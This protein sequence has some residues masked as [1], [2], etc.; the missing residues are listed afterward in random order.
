M[1]TSTETGKP[2][3]TFGFSG[4][5]SSN[6]TN[7]G[8]SLLSKFGKSNNDDFD[9]SKRS[10]STKHLSFLENNPFKYESSDTEEDEGKDKS[11]N[12]CLMVLDPME[13]FAQKLKEKASATK[14]VSESFFFRANDPRLEEGRFFFTPTQ[15]IDE[16][17]SK[18]EVQ[19]PL[20]AQIMKKKL[21]RRAKKQE[22]LSFDLK[23]VNRRSG[24]G[25]VKKKFGR[26]NFN[27]RK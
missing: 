23:G 16:M 22:K 18:H 24:G 1:E 14:G 10:S 3:F 8:F 27:N 25:I 5:E 19:R 2:S 20:L 26:G 17:R 11:S 12:G 4:K 21:R 9:S 6:G 13:L 15:S 7:N